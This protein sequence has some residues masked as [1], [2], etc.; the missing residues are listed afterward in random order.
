MG[1]RRRGR[2]QADVFLRIA[3][4]F[5]FCPV[6][7]C[8]RCRGGLTCSYSTI[9]A[10]E[11][12][13][14]NELCRVR[15]SSAGTKRCSFK[16]GR[17]DDRSDVVHALEIDVIIAAEGSPTTCELVSPEVVYVNLPSSA[18]RQRV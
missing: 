4:L 8:R 9:Q 5:R 7:T 17:R 18:A 12:N 1:I 10:L 16:L 14:K 11:C 3:S 2:Q 15:L 13:K 6:Q